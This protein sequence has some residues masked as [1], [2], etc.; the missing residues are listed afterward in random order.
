[1]LSVTKCGGNGQGKQCTANTKLLFEMIL[2]VGGPLAHNFVSI[3]FL[4]PVQNTTLKVFRKTSF[5]FRGFID[6]GGFQYMATVLQKH[7]ERLGI[8]GVVPVECSEDETSCIELA[9][10]NR[11]TNEVDGFCGTLGAE[12]KCVSP[13]VIKADCIE[14]FN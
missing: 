1:M 11:R 8:V 14:L 9:T 7:K 2:K 5:H 6:E 10:W 4:G 13:C 12:Y 3:N